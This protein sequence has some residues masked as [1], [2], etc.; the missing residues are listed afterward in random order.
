MLFLS[1]FCIFVA[2]FSLL[3]ICWLK[4]TC[5]FVLFKINGH[6][7][8]KVGSFRFFFIF[9]T[10]FQ[11]VDSECDRSLFF[12][13]SIHYAFFVL[14]YIDDIIITGNFLL[15]VQNLIQ[16]LNTEFALKRL[17]FRREWLSMRLWIPGF[18]CQLCLVGIT[19]NQL[20]SY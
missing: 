8:V 14:R 19:D 17:C 3:C 7:H 1:K 2:L 9:C 6:W 15:L 10:Q 4:F 16:K 20:D 12:L 18:S 5:I 11:Y 13:K